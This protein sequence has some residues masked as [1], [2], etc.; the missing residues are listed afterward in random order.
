[1]SIF[2][3]DSN[4]SGP[5]I[6]RLNY[7]RILFRFCCDI[8]VFKKPC[9]G[10]F[11]C[12]FTNLSKN[13]K[14]LNSRSKLTHNSRDTVSLSFN[15]FLVDVTKQVCSIFRNFKI[16]NWLNAVRIAL[17]Q[18]LYALYGTAE[19]FP[20]QQEVTQDT[21]KSSWALS[22]TAI[23]QAGQRWVKLSAFQNINKSSR[24]ALS[25]AGRFPKQQ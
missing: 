12:I 3:H 15:I 9:E 25:Q 13:V 19:R 23:S 5:L 22:R 2:F 17:S 4:P 1:M 7:F 8:R 10:T 11:L 18:N 21:A 24:T 6:N 16:F 14:P 20:E